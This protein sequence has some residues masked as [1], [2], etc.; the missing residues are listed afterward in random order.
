MK[1]IITTFSAI[2]LM[3][4][5]S[6]SGRI[7]PSQSSGPVDITVG[8]FDNGQFYSVNNVPGDTTIPV[9]IMASFT[10]SPYTWEVVCNDGYQPYLYNDQKMVMSADI[11]N[12]PFYST[13]GFILGENEEPCQLDTSSFDSDS[14]GHYFNFKIVDGAS[15]NTYEVEKIVCDRKLFKLQLG[16]NDISSCRITGSFNNWATRN[17]CI[18]YWIRG[19]TSFYAVFPDYA[20]DSLS[21]AKIFSPNDLLISER[22]LWEQENGMLKGF[23]N[24]DGILTIPPGGKPLTVNL[25][26]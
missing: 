20:L 1:F 21:Y 16:R 25:T 8:W 4:L 14:T 10:P 15:D 24:A 9:M 17:S 18:T 13:I 19:S 26:P 7:G 5:I 3:L 11:E 6:C 22:G 2:C 23:V 12:A